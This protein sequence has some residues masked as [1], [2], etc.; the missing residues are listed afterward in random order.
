MG[1]VSS[2]VLQLLY[3]LQSVVCFVEAR[4]RRLRLLLQWSDEAHTFQL[5]ALLAQISIAGLILPLRPLLLLLTLLLI[6]HRT[7]IFRTVLSTEASL[8]RYYKRCY[9][10][11]RQ[12]AFPLSNVALTMLAQKQRRA[13]EVSIDKKSK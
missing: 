3:L 9:E 2:N 4:I 10:E 6:C 8:L 7:R 1:G 13:N 11:R 12:L 5:V